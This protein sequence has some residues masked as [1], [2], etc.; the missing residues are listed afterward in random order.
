MKSSIFIRIPTHYY[1]MA[2]GLSSNDVTLY[3]HFLVIK[4]LFF[5]SFTRLPF[6]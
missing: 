1:I 3:G 6:L 4:I 2:V 5:K